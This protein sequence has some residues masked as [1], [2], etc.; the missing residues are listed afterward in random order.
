MAAPGGDR[1]RVYSGEMASESAESGTHGSSEDPATAHPGPENTS[2]APKLRRIEITNYKALDHLELD[3]PGPLMPGDPDVFVVG[4]KNGVGKTS[5]LECC[6][7]GYIGKNITNI[8]LIS[9]EAKAAIRSGAD[10]FV[11]KTTYASSK[12][13]VMSLSKASTRPFLPNEDQYILR[14]D[15]AE[16][17]MGR[18][19]DPWVRK[20]LLLFHSFRKVAEGSFQLQEML[21]PRTGGGVSSLKTVVMGLLLA[22]S[23]LLENFSEPDAQDRLEKLNDLLSS[24]AGGRIDKLRTNGDNS[25]DIRITTR[26]GASFSFDALSSGQK[27]VISTFFMIWNSTRKQPALVLID[28]PEL[29][30]N[31][32][33]QREFVRQLHKLAPRNQYILATHS[34]DIFASVSEEHR[35]LLVGPQG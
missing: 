34:E 3:I 21:N 9:N 13:S 15:D 16:R 7:L 24:F 31:A 5:L 26:G 32:E 20:D 2:D 27:E 23:G 30:L 14:E 18:T 25:L 11:I 35:V 1:D 22:K 33:W 6:A 8:S 12:S 29:H 10:A 28:E 17:L 19:L 4:S